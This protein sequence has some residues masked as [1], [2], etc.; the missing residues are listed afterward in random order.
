GRDQFPRMRRQVSDMGTAL[1]DRKRMD[2]TERSQEDP[3]RRRTS[4]QDQGDDR[5]DG[6]DF[7][8]HG[9]IIPQGKRPPARHDSLTGPDGLSRSVESERASA[10]RRDLVGKRKEGQGRGG[11]FPLTPHSSPKGGR[12]E[13]ALGR[14]L[15]AGVAL[16]R[17]S[18][19]PTGRT[20]SV[21]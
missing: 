6:V 21:A 8:W 9:V 7:E 3:D 17:H 10:N 11:A 16:A 12:R 4:E 20:S 2:V 14:Q 19:E 5:Q 18:Y 1:G 13:R 15:N